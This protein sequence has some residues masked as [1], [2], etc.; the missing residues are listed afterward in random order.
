[1]NQQ[2]G[3]APNGWHENGGRKTH[4]CVTDRKA[5]G[6]PDATSPISTRGKTEHRRSPA[7]EAALRLSTATDRITIAALDLVEWK[8]AF[9]HGAIQ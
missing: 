7:R 4:R 2:H 6:S 5:A 3:R 1:M 8:T 9:R